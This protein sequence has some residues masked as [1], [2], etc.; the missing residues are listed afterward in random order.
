MQSILPYPIS[1][2]SILILSS[3][4]RLGLLVASLLPDFP[5]KNLNLLCHAFGSYSEFA[6]LERLYVVSWRRMIDQAVRP[7]LV[8]VQSW[9]QSWT[10]TCG[11]HGGWSGTWT[12]FPR[13]SFGFPP[14]HHAHMHP[15]FGWLQDT[16]KCRI[17]I[18]FITE[19]YMCI[20]IIITYFNR[21][22][23]SMKWK[24]RADAILTGTKIWIRESSNMRKVPGRNW[25]SGVGWWV[26]RWWRRERGS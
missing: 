14:L 17:P 26:R 6:I 12:W 16:E 11:V 20:W 18:F 10:T 2:T 25:T 8:T 24:R 22:L 5:P 3:H 7:R 23:L 1:L 19:S 13:S 15:A 9:L 4:L 21:S